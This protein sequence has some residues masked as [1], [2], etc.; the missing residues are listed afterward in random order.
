MLVMPWF[1][2]ARRGVML[3]SAWPRGLTRYSLR[4]RRQRGAPLDALRRI[5]LHGVCYDFF[6]VTGQIYVDTKR[7]PICAPRRR[8]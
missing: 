1:F 7:R 5:L 4:L 6:F 3:W 2:S 8:A